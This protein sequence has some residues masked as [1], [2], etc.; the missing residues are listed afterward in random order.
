MGVGI[1]GGKHIQF[2]SHELVEENYGVEFV[3]REW[4]L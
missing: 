2:N 3:G 1:V 4:H